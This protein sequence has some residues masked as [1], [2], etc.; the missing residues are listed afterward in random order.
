MVVIPFFA[1]QKHNALVIARKE[2]GVVLD[3]ESLS[4]E[5]FQKAILDVIN[6]SKY[7]LVLILTIFFFSVA[8]KDK[9]S[10]L[11]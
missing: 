4:K 7:D 5:E 10:F 11:S 1:D 3:F 2:M 9:S 6:D 8:T